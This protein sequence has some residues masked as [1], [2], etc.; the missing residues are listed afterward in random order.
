[1]YDRVK[2]KR[3]RYDYLMW[4]LSG[5][6]LRFRWEWPGRYHLVGSLYLLLPTGSWSSEQS[7]KY[8]L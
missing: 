1:M 2:G 4:E 6:A 5:L 8:W 3:G 7:F